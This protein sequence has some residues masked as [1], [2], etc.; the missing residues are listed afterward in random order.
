MASE[1]RGVIGKLRAGVPLTPAAIDELER[2]LNRLR[3]AGWSM[4]IEADDAVRILLEENQEAI[5]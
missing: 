1:L 2:L 4:Y 5:R 3:D